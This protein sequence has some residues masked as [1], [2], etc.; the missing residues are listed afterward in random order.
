MASIENEE[1][2]MR[3]QMSRHHITAMTKVISKEIVKISSSISL[4]QG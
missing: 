1:H 3:K 2:T 4:E